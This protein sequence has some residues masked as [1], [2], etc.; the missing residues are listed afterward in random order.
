MLLEKHNGVYEYCA[1][2][3]KFCA[4]QEKEGKT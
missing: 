1:V 3:T 4:A 2:K